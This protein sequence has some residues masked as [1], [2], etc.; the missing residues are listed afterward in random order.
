MSKKKLATIILS[1]VSFGIVVFISCDLWISFKNVEKSK[2][3]RIA[4]K[5]NIQKIKVATSFYPLYFFA[6]QIGAEKTDILNIIPVGENPNK[7]KLT[8]QDI[9]LIEKSDIVVLNGFGLEAWQNDARNIVVSANG[10]FIV[11]SDGIG[12]DNLIISDENKGDYNFLMSPK[13][14]NKIIDKIL[15][16]FLQADKQ[17]AEFYKQNAKKLKIEISKLNQDYEAGLKNCKIK[18][19]YTSSPVFSYLARDYNLKQV[20]ISGVLTTS[21]LSD[22]QI[23]NILDFVKTENIK[24]I[25]SEKRGNT[26]LIKKTEEKIGAKIIFINSINNFINIDERNEGDYF[27]KMIENLANL[28][29]ALNCE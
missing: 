13:M 2:E 11:A 12:M 29:T 21:E 3:A 9:T 23:K 15:D 19:I 6:Q 1:V 28:R 22:Q 10:V 25:F 18:N 8:A 26:E 7:Y 14:A 16:G 24:Y 27:L 17:N 5:N 20:L 4:Q